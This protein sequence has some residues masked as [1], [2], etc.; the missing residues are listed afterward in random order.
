[1]LCTSG[2]PKVPFMKDLIYH[3]SMVAKSDDLNFTD[4]TLLYVLP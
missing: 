4:I 2:T 3:N 1:M